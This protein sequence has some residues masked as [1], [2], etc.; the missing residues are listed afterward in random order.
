MGIGIVGIGGYLPERV[1]TNDEIQARTGYDPNLK[2]GLS[3]DAWSRARH[4]G[5][6]RHHAAPGEGASDLATRAAREAIASAGIEVDDLDLIVMATFTGDYRT[7][8][9]AGI[10]QA[11]LASRAKFLQVDS[12]CT[13]FLDASQVAIGMIRAF[14]YRTV[15][16]VTADRLSFLSDPHD[17]LSMTVFGDGA[18]AVVLRDVGGEYGFT[19]VSTGSYALENQAS[20]SG[21]MAYTVAGLPTA[22]SRRTP[23]DRTTPSRSSAE[24]W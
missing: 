4:G 21:A 8:P 24:R 9:A 15:L 14:G 19:S 3:L 13:G 6:R 22:P 10:L 17:W 18:G 11:N 20:A 5:V 1:V 7:P 16:V 12:A 23:I 2:D